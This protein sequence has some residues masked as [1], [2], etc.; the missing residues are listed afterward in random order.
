VSTDVA[1]EPPQPQAV[2]GF[3]A[4][5]LQTLAGVAALTLAGPAVAS[6]DSVVH[7][8]TLGTF[9][10]LNDAA[11]ASLRAVVWLDFYLVCVPTPALL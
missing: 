3:H 7:V 8:L 9:G 6:V 11:P 4:R 5:A 1:Q 2:P 10:P